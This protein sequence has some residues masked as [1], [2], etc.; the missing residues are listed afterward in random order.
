[1]A[2]FVKAV[3]ALITREPDLTALVDQYARHEPLGLS[4]RGDESPRSLLSGPKAL[5]SKNNRGGGQGQRG[6]SPYLKKGGSG[7]STTLGRGSSYDETNDSST[8]GERIIRDDISAGSGAHTY[9]P[10][11]NPHQVA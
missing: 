11:P 8:R 3:S 1:M 5:F 4:K 9:T 2:S 6:Q 7:T 10:A